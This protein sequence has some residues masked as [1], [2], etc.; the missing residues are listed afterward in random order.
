MTKPYENFTERALAWAAKHPEEFV[1]YKDLNVT[2]AI[3]HTYNGDPEKYFLGLPPFQSP[4]TEVLDNWD[5]FLQEQNRVLD[6]TPLHS[7]FDLFYDLKYMY[8]V[9]MVC[10]GQSPA[11][12]N[13]TP[14]DLL[15]MFN[16]YD[17]EAPKFLV[18]AA[19]EGPGS[20]VIWVSNDG[21][22]LTYQPLPDEIHSYIKTKITL[23][24]EFKKGLRV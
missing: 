14:Y 7:S 13:A 21:T 5:E 4:L 10:K 2:E 1:S 19:G 15:K 17:I 20:M 23:T 9:E 12:T 24:E 3:N 22:W 18:D 11:G 8:E 16:D 6:M